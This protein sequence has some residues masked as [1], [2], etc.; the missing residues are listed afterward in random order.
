M[1][2]PT[3]REVRDALAYLLGEVR[4]MQGADGHVASVRRAYRVGDLVAGEHGLK[5]VEDLFRVLEELI[6]V[7]RWPEDDGL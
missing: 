6:Q 7:A 1:R 5:R 2:A 4:A 3:G